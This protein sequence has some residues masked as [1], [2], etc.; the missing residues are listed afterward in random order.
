MVSLIGLIFMKFVIL[1]FLK[2]SYDNFP[3]SNLG[4][5]FI[6]LSGNLCRIINGF[7]S[8]T[9]NSTCHK[10]FNLAGSGGIGDS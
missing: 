4:L 2:N 1:E 6:V 5:I 7:Y 9:E 3:I 8:T 10:I